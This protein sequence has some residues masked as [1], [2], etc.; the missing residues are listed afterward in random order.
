L[1]LQNEILNIE[2]FT[3][4]PSLHLSPL[5]FSPC[6]RR[7]PPANIGDCVPSSGRPRATPPAKTASSAPGFAPTPAS[8]APSAFATRP[9]RPSMRNADERHLVAGN[10]TRRLVKPSRRRLTIRRSQVHFL[11]SISPL[12]EPNSLLPVAQRAAGAIAASPAP[13]RSPLRPSAAATASPA[14]PPTEPPGPNR[15]TPSPPAICRRGTPWPSSPCSRGA[16]LSDPPPPPLTRSRASPSP[17]G[18]RRPGHHRPELP[19]RRL[20]R[21]PAP[22]NPPPH[23]TSPRAETSQR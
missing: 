14:T 7:S 15:P 12:P 19:E 6:R 21:P 3:R 17:T 23:A 9:R 4:L 22:V 18:A 16:S 5:C 2:L 13:W 8:L 20:R 11:L 1:S 10:T